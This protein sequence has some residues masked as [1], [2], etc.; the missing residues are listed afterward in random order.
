MVRNLRTTIGVWVVSLVFF[1]CTGCATGTVSDFKVFSTSGIALADAIPDLYDG[2]FDAVV[3]N[4]AA[5][6][7]LKRSD[8]DTDERK[9]FVVPIIDGL[10][11]R[12]Q[13]LTDLKAHSRLLKKYFGAMNAL[14]ISEAPSEISGSVASFVDQLGAL[15]PKIK[16]AQIGNASV[17]DVLE[18]VTS[19]IVR[20]KI[21]EVLRARLEQ[22]KD[23]IYEELDIHSAALNALAADIQNNIEVT[24]NFDRFALVVQPYVS[25]EN[26][27][28]N[29]RQK[30]HASFAAPPELAAMKK[31]AMAMKDVR[32][33]FK[34]L[35]EGNVDSDGLL[36]LL[37][38]VSDVVAIIEKVEG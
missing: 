30:W 10:K 8:L 4:S 36:V 9:L 31:A 1:V 37:G 12:R 23:V 27:P 28:A 34:A 38:D 22:D 14:A 25:A 19:L 33:N 26:L 7:V 32:D 5:N 13:L 11:E 18:P 15:S 3:D 6:L 21:A 35:V 2:S 17:K 29:W 20:A 24:Q 16:N